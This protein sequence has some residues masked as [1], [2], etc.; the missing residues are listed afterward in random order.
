MPRERECCP[1]HPLLHTFQ[2]IVTMSTR[3]IIERRQEIK[4]AQQRLALAKSHESYLSKTLQSAI[5]AE[6]AA[7]Q[8]RIE[9]ELQ[10]QQSKKQVN[11]AV[12]LLEEVEK[13]LELVDDDDYDQDKST[14]KLVHRESNSNENGS[15]SS[16]DQ[17]SKESNGTIISSKSSTKSNNG[18]SAAILLELRSI[19]LLIKD[20]EWLSGILFRI[21]PLVLGSMESS[22]AA[23]LPASLGG[24]GMDAMFYTAMVV[25][26]AL[27]LDKKTN[28][29]GTSS[30]TKNNGLS[31]DNE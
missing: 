28:I 29:I 20:A 3:Y 10:M 2:Y 16:K 18:K 1:S 9:I 19:R 13:R 6:K 4:A 8:Y 23:L 27:Y 24:G 22:C 15:S 5:T 21:Y 14:K 31:D 30:T 7:K 12:K 25:V 17:D 11:E 26:G